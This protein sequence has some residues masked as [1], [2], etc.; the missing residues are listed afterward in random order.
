[1]A[2]PAEAVFG[3]D[4]IAEACVIVVLATPSALKVLLPASNTIELFGVV[5][6]GTESGVTSRI[7]VDVFA[8][9]DTEMWAARMIALKSTL[10]LAS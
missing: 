6:E 4:M 9:V 3:A 2:M 8:D 1:M 7:A 10:L 5:L